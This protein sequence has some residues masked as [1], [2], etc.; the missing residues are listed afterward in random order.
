MSRVQAEDAEPRGAA[1]GH[2]EPIPR[3]E[4]CLEPL[5]DP[6]EPSRT[7]AKLVPWETALALCR[8]DAAPHRTAKAL[9][10]R[11]HRQ[12][13]QSRQRRRAVRAKPT[14]HDVSMRGRPN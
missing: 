2:V 1:L 13:G 11:P 6:Q 4:S 12:D 9:L 14:F 3:L 8:H 5:S 7:Q 10:R